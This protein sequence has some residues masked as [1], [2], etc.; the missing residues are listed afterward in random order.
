MRLLQ[1]VGVLRLVPDP[2]RVAAVLLGDE[3]GQLAHALGHRAGKRWIA[4][5][6]RNAS[7]RSS[8]AS[9]FGSSVPARCF[10]TYGPAN[11]FCTGTCWS[12]AKP[13]SSA[14]GSSRAACTPSRRR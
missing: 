6:S 8:V 5:C 4:G 7:S 12:I 14:N 2:R 11:A 10:S 9:F 1:I 13:T 3:R